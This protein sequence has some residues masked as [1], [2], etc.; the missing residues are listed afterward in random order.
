MNAFMVEEELMD[1]RDIAVLCEKEHKLLCRDIRAM[2]D[3]GKDDPDLDHDIPQGITATYD[4]RGYVTRY[5]LNRSWSYTLITGY[6]VDL[7]KKVI[8]RWMELEQQAPK[9]PKS[10]AEALRLAA[11]QQ[12]KIQEMLP[13][14]EAFEALM[15]TPDTMSITDAAKHFEV[16]Q[17]AMF[18]FL[19][20]KWRFLTM[21]GMPTQEALDMGILSLKETVCAD[22]KT[23]KQP[24]VKVCQLENLRKA[25]NRHQ[26]RN[27][28]AE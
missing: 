22:G 21:S 12:D 24:C 9:L 11:D 1:S 15:R 13:K 5:Q 6:R 10:F 3:A 4:N 16:R 7:R 23:R 19:R 14:A 18:E 20:D 8:D 2:I 17:S 26:E 28:G 27:G 25:Y